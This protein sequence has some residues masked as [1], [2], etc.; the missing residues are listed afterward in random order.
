MAVSTKGVWLRCK[1]A[2]VQMVKQEA[3][4]NGSRGK[5]QNRP[6]ETQL[7]LPHVRARFNRQVE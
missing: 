2:I 1:Y 7:A 3:L 5:A 6:S 4:E